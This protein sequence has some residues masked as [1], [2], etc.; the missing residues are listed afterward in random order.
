[1][2]EFGVDIGSVSLKW[3]EYV[4]GKL[5]KTEYLKHHGKPYNLLYDLL[6]EKPEI[7]RLILT[8]SSAKQ[9]VD[10]LDAV[11]VNEV[12]ATARGVMHVLP[13]VTSIIEIG[14]EDSKLI[15]V[16][17]NAIT[18]FASNTICAA[19]TGI[20]LDQQARR[21]CYSVEE[22]G[23][24]ALQAKNP[25]RI[26]GRCSVFAKSDMIHLQQIGTKP[27]DLVAGLCLALARNFKSVIAKGKHIT[28]PVAFVGGVA[29]N[30]G[31]VEAFRQVLNIDDHGIIIPDCHDRV[32]AIGAVL[33]H[34]RESSKD[35]NHLMVTKSGLQ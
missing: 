22:L 26:A 24:I 19:G 35:S 11:Y 32:G 6:T 17:N 33:G 4:S 10:I 29:A 23:S 18:D 7:D 27:E 3:A 30:Q 28:L 14:G 20:F 12:E 25:A 1:M 15:N 5:I 34:N 13:H 21:L 2:H 16:K 9:L 8:G 31:M